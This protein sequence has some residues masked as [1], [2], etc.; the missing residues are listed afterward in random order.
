MI[1]YNQILDLKI[2]FSQYNKIATFDFLLPSV[3]TTETQIY[4]YRSDNFWVQLE[5]GKI[6]IDTTPK[7]VVIT[8]A[9]KE[10]LLQ[11]E[12]IIATIVFPTN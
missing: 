5:N 11:I 1:T 6:I 9:Y 12:T 8:P 4:I 2:L 10:E 7:R 3:I